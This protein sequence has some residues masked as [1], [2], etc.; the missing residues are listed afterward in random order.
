MEPAT[1]PVSSDA[2]GGELSTEFWSQA[3]L[4]D[5]YTGAG[6]RP[7]EADILE[8]HRVALSGR[9]LEVGV[10]A[11][12]LTRHLCAIATD[13]HGIDISDAMVA[14]TRRACPDAT[15]IRWDLRDL[16]A[17][18][19]GSFDAVVAA[20][21]VIDVLTHD[22]R[23]VA[24]AG[25]VR[26]L[27]PGGLL[28]MS[29]HNR[30]AASSVVGP[31]RQLLGHLRAGRM[32]SAAGG[33]IRFPRRVANRRR[34]RPL[35][36]GHPTYAIVNDSAHDYSILHYYISRD[37]QVTQLADHGFE[38]LESLDLEGGPVETGAAAAGSPEL[39]YVARRRR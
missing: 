20:F 23:E 14:A 29:S 26:V 25:F 33:V 19:D 13:V 1:R 2:A 11:G 22:D 16:S 7:V 12:R 9:V 21:N 35:E 3:D 37:A 32:R 24:L 6:L 5:A 15:I 8:R 38:L 27:A 36:H 17:H 30:A 31:G 28:V 4:V 18:E 34:L 10:G 39:H